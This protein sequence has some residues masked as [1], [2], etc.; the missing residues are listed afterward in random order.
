MHNYMYVHHRTKPFLQLSRYILNY[1]R[2]G[3]FRPGTLPTD[4]TVLSE[5]LAEAEYYQISGLTK[6]LTAAMQ[7]T[8]QYDHVTPEKL[9]SAGRRVLRKIVQK[10]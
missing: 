5:I 10:K 7:S 4:T 9:E 2:D 1:L 8:N 3:G 6:L